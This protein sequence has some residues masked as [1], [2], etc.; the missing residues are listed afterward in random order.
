MKVAIT[1]ASGFLGSHVLKQLQT[2]DL[3]VVDVRRSPIDDAVTHAGTSV[4]RM[5][6]ADA[7]GA[8]D[9][10][11][12]PDLLIHL[13]WEGLPAYQS[14]RH[15][16][17]ELP[18]QTNFL[19]ACVRDGLKRLA[20]AGTCFEYGLQEG[21]LDE[22][23]PLLPATQYGVAKHRLYLALRSLADVGKVELDWGRFFYLFGPGQ[24]PSSL[25]SQLMTAIEERRASFDM[26]GGEQLRDFLPASE[27]ARLFVDL[28]LA[29]GAS[30]A[31]NICSGQPVSVS[32]LV[33]RW[34]AER[35][36]HID[37][38]KGHFPYS[39]FEP[40]AFWGRRA[41]LDAIIGSQRNISDQHTTFT[42]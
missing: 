6:L 41:K 2:R 25:Y 17:I 32:T 39:P 21:E 28:A 8:F 26:S 5:S 31:V 34:V 1:G 30:G 9:A 40:M 16:E 20:V 3:D 4:V 11:G 19:H 12:R 24:A 37:L 7:S 38:N 23:A 22:H 29:S 10:M 36:A 15:V 13:A 35:G 42:R 18:A 27:A 14:P 33:D